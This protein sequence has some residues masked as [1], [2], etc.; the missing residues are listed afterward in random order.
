MT[1]GAYLAL[2]EVLGAQHPISDQHDELLFIV[3]HQTKEL[4]LKQTDRGAAAAR[5]ADRRGPV[6]GGPQDL[7]RCRAS[8]R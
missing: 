3:I 7:S 2:D 1:Y 8:S 5:G 4:W 6:G